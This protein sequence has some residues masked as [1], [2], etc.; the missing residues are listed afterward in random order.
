MPVSAEQEIILHAVHV[1]CDQLIAKKPIPFAA[2]NREVAT[3][4]AI[5]PRTLINW[6]KKGCP[7]DRGQWRV[8]D[9]MHM[10]PYL[11]RRAKEKFARQFWRRLRSAAKYWRSVFHILNEPV[12]DSLNK[13]CER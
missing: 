9:W 13:I 1:L 12:P 8:L 2:T 5:S 7:F 3:K 6:R 11:P 4:Y 10:R